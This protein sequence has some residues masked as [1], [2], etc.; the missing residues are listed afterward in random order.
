LLLVST[1]TPPIFAVCTVP[2]AAAAGLP[3]LVPED[4]GEE[5]A[6]ELHAARATASAAAA[7][8]ASSIR[9]R[10]ERLLSRCILVVMISC[11][12]IE[13]MF[14]LDNWHQGKNAY[15]LLM[16][17]VRVIVRQMTDTATH[18]HLRYDI[19]AMFATHRCASAEV[20]SRV[21]IV[22]RALIA[23]HVCEAEQAEHQVRSEIKI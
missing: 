14:L 23:D 13:F 4:E 18:G 1:V 6:D 22:D 2:E 11:P 12:C 19:H 16:P 3:V 7:G 15:A 20:D 5:V 21:P 9:R 17:R 8:S 10:A